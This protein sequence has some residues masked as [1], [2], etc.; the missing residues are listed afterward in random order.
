[1]DSSATN[2]CLHCMREMR[3]ATTCPHCGAVG[4]DTGWTPPGLKPGTLLHGKYLVGR[5]LGRGG[6]AVTYL[7]MQ[8]ALGNRVAIKEY[9][10]GELAARDPN[11]SQVLPRHTEDGHGKGGP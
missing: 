7:G 1:M 2:I 10:P 6:F 11:T 3:D 5:V 8:T 9:F 4:G